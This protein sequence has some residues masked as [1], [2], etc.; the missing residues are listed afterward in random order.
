MYHHGTAKAVGN[1]ETALVERQKDKNRMM[2]MWRWLYKNSVV[3]QKNY[4]ARYFSGR[5][6]LISMMVV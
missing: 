5:V 1:N 6:A 2:M 4:K 3:V